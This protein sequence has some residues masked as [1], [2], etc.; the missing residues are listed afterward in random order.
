MKSIS[1]F[2]IQFISNVLAIL[3]CRYWLKGFY[4]SGGILVL[5]EIALALTIFNFLVKPILKFVLSPFIILTFGL[6]IVLINAF[7]LWLVSYLFSS[8]TIQFGWPLI[9]ATI[10][11]GFTNTTIH[12]VAKKY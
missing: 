9:Y 2:L 1:Y 4:F 12:L 10:I 5:S 6:L 8:L 3:V 11:F 7:G